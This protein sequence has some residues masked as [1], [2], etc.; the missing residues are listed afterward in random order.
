MSNVVG[1]S[2]SALLFPFMAQRGR[3]THTYARCFA[4]LLFRFM[5]QVTGIYMCGV[6]VSQLVVSFHGLKNKAYNSVLSVSLFRV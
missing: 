3:R 6:L 2:L 1:A 5:V 4:R